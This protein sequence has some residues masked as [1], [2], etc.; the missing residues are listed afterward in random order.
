MSTLVPVWIGTLLHYCQA[1]IYTND[2][3]LRISQGYESAT[4]IADKYGFTNMGQ[5][6][7]LKNYYIFHHHETAP[8][9]TVPNNALTARITKETEV[10][11]LQQ[12][13][14]Q[15]RVKR[16]LYSFNRMKPKC[17]ESHHQH[18]K[19]NQWDNL[20][21]D[22][23]K[24]HQP[25]MNIGE[26]WRRGYTGRGVV[27]SILDYNIDGEHPNLKMNYDALASFEV[28]G[29]ERLTPP[30]YSETAANYHGT[31][32]A[33]M[34][35]GAISTNHSLCSM[36][37]AF[38][39]RIGG[40][41]I[42]EGVDGE[43]T[44]MVEA[45]A[46]NFRPQHVDIY[47]AGW[48]PEDDGTT[49]DGPGPLARLALRTGVQTGRHGR[50][51]VYVWASGSGGRRGDH[52][53]CDGYANS[54]Y[55]ISIGSG[56]VDEERCSSTLATASA[57][58]EI[59]CGT[60]KWG[61]ALS[62]SAA[63]GVIA[64]TLEA[65][66]LLTWRDIQHII[67]W[68]SDY[69]K[70]AAADWQTNGA[71]HKV[72]HLYGFGLLDAERMVMQAKGW[73]RVPP[74]RACTVKAHTQLKRISNEDGV[75]T[76]TLEASGCSAS[77]RRR[78][79]VAFV[80]H[81][82]A[83][84]TL[85]CRR[86]GNLTIELTS[87]LG[88]VSRLL[89]KRPYDNSTEGFHQWEFMTT[90]CWGEQASGEWTLNIRDSPS[91]G[92]EN[93]P[94]GILQEWSL[95][96]YGTAGPVHPV[97]HR[98]VRSPETP[99]DANFTEEY[100]GSCNPE[101]SDDGCDGPSQWEC[102][103]CAHFFL[104]FKNNT[105]V[106]VSTCPQGF[107]ADRRRCK[108]CY[109]TCES[110]TGSRSDQ[111]TS[112]Q[113][114]Y[115]LTEG[116]NTC[117]DVCEESYFLDH[118]AKMCR[119]CSEMCLVC[120]SS[121]IC[122]ECK[123]DSSLR[124]NRCQWN[125]PSGMYYNEAEGA[126]KPCHPVCADCAGPDVEACTRCANGYLMEEWKCVASC[127]RG[128]FSTNSEIAD[129]H[130]MCRRCDA[131]CLTCVGP[132]WGNCSSC[133]S[134]HSLQEG[135][136]V[137]HMPCADG[138]YQDNNET[139]HPCHPTCLKCTGP[140]RQECI[141]CVTSHVLDKG[142]CLTEC[143]RGKYPGSG[144]CHLCDHTCATCMEA[145]PAKCTSC[146]TDKFGMARYL[147]KGSCVE[148]C[149]EAFY[150]TEER[151]CEP[152]S[153]HCTLCMSSTHCL[154]CNS[155]YSVEDGTCAKLECGEGEVEDP[156]YSNCMACE[157]GCKHCVLYNPK[158]CLSC[159]EGFY[160][161][162]DSCYKNCPAKTYSMDEEMTCVP[163][164]DN[165]VSCDQHE[166]YWCETDLFL[167]DG[168][169]VSVC[170]EG[171]YGDEDTNECEECHATCGSCSGREDDDCMSC[172]D[173][174]SLE[175]GKC[176]TDNM[177][178]MK[179]FLSDD[180]Q[181]VECHPSCKSCSGKNKNQCTKCPKEHFLSPQKTC[182][183]K[184][185][186]GSFGERLSGECEACPVGCLYCV[187]LEHCT[188]CLSRSMTFFL[189][190][191][192]CVQQCVR[193]YPVG[194]VC[195]NCASDCASC[196][197]NASYCLSCEEPLLLLNHQCVEHCPPTHVV[198]VREC[199]PCPAACEECDPLGECAA[200]E[201][202]H[203]LHEGTCVLDCPDG[204][205]GDHERSECLGCHPSCRLCDGSGHDD[206]DACVNPRDILRDGECLTECPARTFMDDETGECQ[207]CDISCLTCTG[208]RADSCTDCREGYGL[209]GHGRC[210]PSDDECSRHEYLDERGKCRLCHKN[211]R[212]C[213][214]PGKNRCLDC[215][216][217]YLLLNGSCVDECPAGFYTDQLRQKCETCHPTCRSCSGKESHECLNCK[218]GLFRQ[219]RECVETC[220]RSHYG[221]RNSGTCEACDPNCGECTGD[222]ACL[223][224]A[225]GLV[226]MPQEGR[227]VHHCPGGFYQHRDDHG[228]TAD[229]ERC[230]SNCATCSGKST[231]C[232]SCGPGY[233][234][235]G[236]TCL[237]ACDT[238]K[239]PLTKGSSHSCEDCHPSCMR[240]KGPG[241]TNC[242]ACPPYAILESEGRCLLC[243]HTAGSYTH[244]C[245]N[246]T[247][248]T[249]VCILS[250][251]LPFRNEE[252]DNEGEGRG[253]LA[254]FIITSI[255][256]AAGL[257]AAIV[258]IRRSRSKRTSSDGTPCGY[259]KLDSASGSAS[260]GHGSS[261]S[262]YKGTQMVDLGKRSADAK[263]RE[264][265]EE[266]EDI[267][268]MSKD[269]TVYRKFRYG[270]LGE[271]DDDLEY[272]DERYMYR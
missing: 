121:S 40:I 45:Q 59:N 7:S 112:C 257:V 99:E 135:V 200:C 258:L 6:Q 90:H 249:G 182:V 123:A 50:G 216:Q 173:G 267:V 148:A 32:C 180:G 43:V 146:N 129:G 70:L 206:C 207:E 198:L 165:C 80:E 25:P 220:Q 221:N 39:S 20:C 271:D 230:H 38:R 49:V 164:D 259:E 133:S 13:V 236:N 153:Q 212:R 228:L 120:M 264:D 166:C 235:S 162:Q 16:S 190:D 74:Q 64:L 86:R 227:C 223:S 48:G 79:N 91:E 56:G 27:V 144:R 100:A 103:T 210:V 188:R 154:R 150:H 66:P 31:R 5:M 247:E 15:K 158:H 105:R 179:T 78:Q 222:G 266:E 131:S 75:L 178:P 237:S 55:T 244:H 84:V 34:V 77:F 82:V 233:I 30:S 117:T 201:E 12:Q 110:C 14:I 115:H 95:V 167:S 168:Y 161:L 163:C 224:C 140:W 261:S 240:C 185:P 149:P 28:N 270:Q 241:A 57:T 29:Q 101:C 208:P 8:R 53:S 142:H 197:K 124:G 47:L 54:I 156:D 181:C 107:W 252:G 155:S 238:T 24:G 159:K 67:V 10:E 176:M 218:D 254:V 172:N 194:Q 42:L 85:A 108:R 116:T 137:L 21:S 72:S 152:C 231:H 184:C 22:D 94:T 128:F 113:D 250:N 169:C 61:S 76:S 177:C 92:R 63:A 171:F 157:E 145:G 98:L 109:A 88:T 234:L 68:T 268:Y 192:Q 52:C 143:A 246:C 232:E 89:D 106:C 23:F 199:R 1:T 71:G 65:N 239:Y 263:D 138:E 213:F 122:T 130:E 83:R 248:T 141:S 272:D 104:K 151:T 229:C 126:C 96:I 242:S 209:A 125:C 87:P 202:Y 81:V 160:N 204:F 19:D 18:L 118:D 93:S 69:R 174:K 17:G 51:S 136:C 175:N 62:A 37:V 26:A 2:W 58:H 46:L 243:C 73:R 225:A 4:R 139:C 255:L 134:G 215:K 35:A 265:E 97:S 33:A 11:W 44:D 195:R 253:N 211:C 119:K 260:G 60:A 9:S 170:P 189:Q 132:S 111:C 186:P 147:H 251:N 36:G 219:G 226:L 217:R 205:F 214:G 41:R 127:S 102:V 196:E 245:C 114:G 193:G 203:F 262:C 269:G 256:L 187:D 191:G 3:A 183:T